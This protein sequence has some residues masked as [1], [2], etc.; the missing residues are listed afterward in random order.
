MRSCP[1]YVGANACYLKFAVTD[2]SFVIVSVQVR[3]VPVQAPAQPIQGDPGSGVAVIVTTAPAANVAP[4]GFV[5]TV[6]F[7]VLLVASLNV[8]DVVVVVV[9]GVVGV[10]VGLGTGDVVGVRPPPPLPPP[11]VDEP[12]FRTVTA[13]VAEPPFEFH[14][15]ANAG[16]LAISIEPFHVPSSNCIVPSGGLVGSVP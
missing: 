16:A 6:P 3:A 2:M 13:I 1:L 11:P 5:V 14:T 9:G 12:E 10:G 4:P 15:V 8:F 7:P